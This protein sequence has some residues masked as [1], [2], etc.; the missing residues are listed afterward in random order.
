M[1]TKRLKNHLINDLGYLY[2]QYQSCNLY[3]GEKNN[4]NSLIQAKAKNENTKSNGAEIIL[5]RL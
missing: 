5:N 4:T 3:Q 1:N 2:V